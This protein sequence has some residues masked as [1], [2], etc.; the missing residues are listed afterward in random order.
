[1]TQ[2]IQG[3]EEL[4]ARRQMRRESRRSQTYK[5]FLRHLCDESGL[6]EADA[7]AAASSVLCAFEQRILQ[8]E[9]DHLNAQLPRKLQELLTRCERHDDLPPRKFGR[10]EL[11]T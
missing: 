1:M 8:S 10:G 3:P 7:E 11:V 9:A 6:S 2:R 4:E 5:R